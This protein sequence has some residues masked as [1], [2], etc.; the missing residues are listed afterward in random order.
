MRTMY[1]Q[2]SNFIQH[3]GSLVDL[4]EFRRRA[5]LAQEDSLARQPEVLPAAEAEPNF[6]PVVMTMSPAQR[7]RARRIRRAWTLDAYA[8][9]AVILMTLVFTLRVLL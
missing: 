9:L 3:T 1:Y 8:S 7:R 6:C 4:G 2:T 5:A